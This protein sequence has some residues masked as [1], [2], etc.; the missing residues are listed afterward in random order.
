MIRI[1]VNAFVTSVSLACISAVFLFAPTPPVFA[2]LER[3]DQ[4]VT[5]VEEPSRLTA[6]YE[7]EGGK[8]HLVVLFDDPL[9]GGLSRQRASIRLADNQNF[10]LIIGRDEDGSGGRKF[11]FSRAGLL[12]SIRAEDPDGY[13][14]FPQ[15]ADS[16]TLDS[17]PVAAAGPNGASP[18]AT[19]GETRNAG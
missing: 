7:A 10:T 4:P 8:L 15:V 2:A 18:V 14:F 3:A 9:D 13:V 19:S 11:T 1:M 6:F 12:V 5:L 17:R 16:Q